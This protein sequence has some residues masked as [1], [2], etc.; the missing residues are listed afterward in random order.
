MKK[1]WIYL[2]L[3]PII[4]AIAANYD[5]KDWMTYWNRFSKYQLITSVISILGF[6][7]LLYFKIKNYGN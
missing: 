2:Y 5:G 4:G 1:Y 3:I 6:Y 7:L